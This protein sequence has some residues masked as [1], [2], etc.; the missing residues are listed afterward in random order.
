MEEFPNLCEKNILEL[1][2]LKIRLGEFL[3]KPHG[4][5]PEKNNLISEA[6][7]SEMFDEIHDGIQANCWRIS[8]GISEDAREPVSKCIL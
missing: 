3:E 4:K 6:I 2:L 7:H 5:N 8:K 1:H